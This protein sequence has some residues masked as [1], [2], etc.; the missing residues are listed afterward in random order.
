MGADVMSLPPGFVLEEEATGLP[1]GFVLDRRASPP[2]APSQQAP[3]PSFYDRLR[4]GLANIAGGAEIAGTMASGA[5]AEPVAG[6]AG[7]AQTLNPFADTGAGAK[8]VESV[9]NTLTYQPRTAAG[10]QGLQAVGNVLEPVANAMNAAEQF[11]GDIGYNLAGPTGG[12]IGE[13]LPTAALQLIGMGGGRKVANVA[14]ATPGPEDAALLSAAA[15][16]DIPLLTSDVFPPKGYAG[17]FVQSVAEKLGPLGTGRTRQFQQVARENAVKAFAE[18]M[19]VDL[20][21][22][23]AERM[24]KSLNQQLASEIKRAGDMR[25]SAV[26]KLDTFGEVPLNRTQAIVSREIARQERLGARAN[27]AHIQNLQNTLESMKGGNFSLVKDIRTEV[28]DDL[29]ALRKAEDARTEASLQAVKSAIDDDLKTFA[30]AN[31]RTAAA[32]WV[33][34]NRIFAD[35]YGRAKDTEL[36]RV[37]MKGEATPEVLLPI[38]KGGKPS[39]LERLSRSMGVEGREAARKAIIQDALKE[40]KFFEVD[41]NPNPDAFVN[42]LNRPNRQ[43]AIRVFFGGRGKAELE[44]LQRVLDATRRAQQGSALVKTGEQA[45]PFLGAGAMTAGMVSDPVVTGSLIGSASAVIKAYESPVFRNLLMKLANTKKGTRAE[46]LLV[47]Q[48]V[49]IAVSGQQ[50][51]RAEREA[52]Q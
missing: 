16:S 22:P 39:E 43:Q 13:T 9:R 42:A 30:A 34:S 47:D 50:A 48:A 3:E 45:I 23:F 14:R 51:S 8:A 10:Q 21:S 18:A 36:K 33:R 41:A 38:L 28:I 27:T 5:L 46:N 29:K 52:A 17:R 31:D 40:S 4:G 12:A 44:G 32:D 1:P 7:I 6:I 20:D 2:E 15:R 25:T 11:T 37:L 35:A 24:V 26:T 49:T 19:D